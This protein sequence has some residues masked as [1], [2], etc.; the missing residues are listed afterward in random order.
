MQRFDLDIF[1]WR[2]ERVSKFQSFGRE[3]NRLKKHLLQE[4]FEI[5][6]VIVIVITRQTNSGNDIDVYHWLACKT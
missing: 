1:A 4:K 2:K 6:I 5:Y 3:L